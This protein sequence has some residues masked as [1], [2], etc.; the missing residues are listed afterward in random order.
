MYKIIQKRR[1]FLVISGL[2][3]LISIISLSI[4]GLNFGT[5][6]TGGT[7]M[8]LEFKDMQRP[9]TV[10]VQEN[11]NS[12]LGN[13][14]A[15]PSGEDK[16]IL[17]FKAIDEDTH[18][19]VLKNLK[20]KL[21]QNGGSIEESRFE[22]IGP[23]IGKEM[24]QKALWAI[25][26]VNL[27]IMVYVSW[28]FRKVSKPVPSWVY[29]LGAIIALIHDVLITTGL[30]SILGHFFGVE[31]NFMIV[32]ALLTI[33]GYSVNDTIVVYDRARENLL[34]AK[35]SDF[36]NTINESVNQTLARSINTT[37]TTEL[38]LLALYFFGG[39]TIKY[40]VVALLFGI[41]FGAYSSIFIAT[42]LVMEWQV[43]NNKR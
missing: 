36:E 22:S 4:W 40:F 5:D 13:I 8:E 32:V 2:L 39:D 37:L 31:F 9:E 19:L 29:A 30:F 35:R 11:L 38:T 41:F 6:F 25:I 24:K 33:L 7:F 17:K 1:I 18:Q 14:D 34:R 20:E 16:L 12:I 26:L 42:A 27:G 3:S 10:V 23:I 43:W 21:I 15:K 28:A